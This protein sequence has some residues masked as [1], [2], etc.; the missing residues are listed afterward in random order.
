[1]A[2]P[3]LPRVK[4]VIRACRRDQARRLL[5]EALRLEDASE[6]RHLATEALDRAGVGGFVRA[7]RKSIPQQMINAPAVP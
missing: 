5:G 1:M 6:V 2:G 4:Q 7:G 3:D